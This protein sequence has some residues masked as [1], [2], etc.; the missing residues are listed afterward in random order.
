MP[1]K[2]M[3]VALAKKYGW[4]YKTNLNDAILSTYKDYVRVNKILNK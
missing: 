4:E 1:R 2:V 3:D